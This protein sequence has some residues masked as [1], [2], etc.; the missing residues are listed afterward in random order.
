[1]NK[2]T[3]VE[4]AVDYAEKWPD[5]HNGNKL[6]RAAKL[7]VAAGKYAIINNEILWMLKTVK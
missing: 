3:S 6:D 4:S 1:M 2:S 5:S 7:N